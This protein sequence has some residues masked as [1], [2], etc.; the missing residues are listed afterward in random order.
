[1]PLRV[2]SLILGFLRPYPWILPSVAVLGVMASLAE[3]IGIGLLIPFLAVLTD[4]SIPDGGVVAEYGKRYAELFP[5][6]QRILMVSITIV[7]LVV[8]RCLINFAY[9]GILT[10]AGTQVMHE[11]RGRLAR[12]FMG[13]SY[14]GLTAQPQ[15]QQ[16]NAVDGAC[17]PRR[18]RR[19]GFADHAGQRRDGHDLRDAVAA[20]LLEDDTGD[21]GRVSRSPAS[22]PVSSSTAATAPAEHVEEGGAALNETVVQMLNGMRMIR[23][24]GQE[25]R[26]IGRFEQA[27]QRVRRAQLGCSSPGGPWRR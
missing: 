27:S 18:R 12:H 19:H 10:F 15:G 11:L 6:E 13:V 26:E 7:A 17:Q 25:D 21:H 20:D 8:G 22:S 16:V 3:G 4:G 24:F 5:E 9:V 1:M 14:T 2:F 23:M